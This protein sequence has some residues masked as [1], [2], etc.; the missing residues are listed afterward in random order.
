M[1]DLP[2][3]VPCVENESVGLIHG[4]PSVLPP[5]NPRIL[6]SDRASDNRKMILLFFKEQSRIIF[7]F[8]DFFDGAACSPC[9]A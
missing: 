2:G 6:I 4:E 5:R 8:R 1:T 9:A 7:R 3:G